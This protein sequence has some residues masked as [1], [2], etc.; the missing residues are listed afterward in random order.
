MNFKKIIFFLVLPI[1]LWNCKDVK[2]ET[3]FSSSE[4]S[5]T[6]I[7]FPD[8]QIY[9][10]DRPSWRRSSKKEVFTDMTQWVAD[11]AKADNIKF[12]L[13]MGDIVNED[14]E[15]YQ[16]ENAN[17]AM[18]ILDGVVPYAMVVGNHDMYLGNEESPRDSIR[19]TT[20]FNRTFPHSRYQK[21]DWYGG[22]MKKDWFIP[23]DSYDNNYH[24]FN[25]GKLEFMIVNLEAGPTDAMLDWANNLIAKYP[26]KRVIVMTHSYMLGND[27]RDYP[28]GFGYLPPN[29][30]TGEEIWEKLIKKHKNIFLV[31]SGHIGNTN[32]HRGL[33]ASKGINGNTVYQ[34]L[35]G[36]AFDGWLRI[37]RFVPAENKIHVKSYSPWKPKHPKEQ[38]RQY[39]FSL[40]GYNRDSIHQYELR[41][42]MDLIEK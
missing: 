32:D 2:K 40:P 5:F 12:V 18:S 8:T 20:N 37:L 31:L 39:E 7:V 29:S 11:R 36:D 16:W 25:Q 17:K 22:R 10:K 24:F 42:T 3:A 21:E 9:S 34:Q 19:N 6:L 28:D 41:Y 26:S 1:I 35:H 30:N 15:P 13:H 23:H 33:M 38:L 4:D 14:Y 27:K